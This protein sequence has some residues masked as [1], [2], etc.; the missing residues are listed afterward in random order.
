MKN[1][2]SIALSP[3]TATANQRVSWLPASTPAAASSC[4]APRIRVIQ[5]QA[6][7]LANT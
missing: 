1:F 4:S 7:R 3:I 6:C 2:W 5:P